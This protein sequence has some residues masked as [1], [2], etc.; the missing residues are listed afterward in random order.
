MGKGNGRLQNNIWG[1]K[2]GG[3]S[4]RKM[5]MY[6]LESKAMEQ[7]AQPQVAGSLSP[8]P[9]QR[10]LFLHPDRKNKETECKTAAIWGS[11]AENLG[12]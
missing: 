1:A 2:G 4:N 7:E 8:P 6:V 10:C 3:Y 9:S 12:V 11:S 5:H